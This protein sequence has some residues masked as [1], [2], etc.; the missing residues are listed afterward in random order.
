[1]VTLASLWLP[2]V[3]SAVAVFVASAIL[4]MVL[5]YHRKD[6]RGVTN[7][8]ALNDAI[9]AQNLGGGMYMFP[10]CGS[11]AEMK[12]PAN[13]ERFKRGPWGTLI[14]HGRMPSMGRALTQWFIHLLIVSLLVGYLA[15]LTLGAGADYR[16]VFRIVST[17]AF[18]AYSM[19]MVAGSI[20]EGKPWSFTA[21]HMFDGLIYALLTAG[22]FGWRWP[23]A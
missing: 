5:P 9:R 4:W 16:A 22:I 19:G 8:P 12:E 1:M 7:E 17:S 14:L 3:V 18:L 20:W 23:H 13:V 21:K 10:H 2:I 11:P 15:T 6:W